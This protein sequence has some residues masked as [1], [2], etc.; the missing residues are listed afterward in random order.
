MLSPAGWLE[1]ELS[2]SDAADEGG[3]LLGVEDQDGTLAVLL[4]VAD[5]YPCARQRLL[6]H[7]AAANSSF[8]S[9]LHLHFLYY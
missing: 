7:E 8:R 3:P 5:G 9:I 1:V 4:A 6:R 2:A